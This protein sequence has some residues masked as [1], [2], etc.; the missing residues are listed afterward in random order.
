[1]TVT[2][3]NCRLSLRAKCSIEKREDE[4]SFS[5]QNTTIVDYI[6]LV[7]MKM[8][9]YTIC[10]YPYNPI[11]TTVLCLAFGFANGEKFTD[12]PETNL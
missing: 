2:V 5:I 12:P 1:M 7:C 10:I 6:L 8:D 11:S 9:Q 4:I 3:E